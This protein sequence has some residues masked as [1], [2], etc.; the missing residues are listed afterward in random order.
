M[1]DF[2]RRVEELDKEQTLKQQISEYMNRKGFRTQ[3]GSTDNI[4]HLFRSKTDINGVITDVAIHVQGLQS[5][6]FRL[7][8]DISRKGNNE[9]RSIREFRKTGLT[10]EDLMTELRFL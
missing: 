1:T 6:D 4:L 10:M 7:D 2:T 8:T 3:G 5:R 9:E